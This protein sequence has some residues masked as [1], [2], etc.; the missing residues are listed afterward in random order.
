MLSRRQADL[1]S[2][3]QRNCTC[4][5]LR[6]P[7]NL[8][9]LYCVESWTFPLAKTKSDT[10]AKI[11]G[12]EIVRSEKACIPLTLNLCLLSLTR[13]VVDVRAPTHPDLRLTSSSVAT[14]AELTSYPSASCI[15]LQKPGAL[16]RLLVRGFTIHT[17]NQGKMPIAREGM[18][19]F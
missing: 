17:S 19:A 11:L 7:R 12:T 5:N 14:V 18:K 13:N 1:S 9:E 4:G 2:C 6:V 8:S 3:E 16:H 10:V 15:E